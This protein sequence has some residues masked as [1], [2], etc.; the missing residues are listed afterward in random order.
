MV[1]FVI[2][3]IFHFIFVQ[4]FW[5]VTALP[6]CFITF[7][8]DNLSESNLK[9]FSHYLN[10]YCDHSFNSLLY[11]CRS[12][13][14]IRPPTRGSIKAVY[15]YLL[16]VMH[17]AKRAGVFDRYKRLMIWTTGIL[18]MHKIYLGLGN[19]LVLVTVMLKSHHKKIEFLL[20]VLCADREK[21]HHYDV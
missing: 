21:C 1:I 7:T 17:W 4:Y 14:F 3:T 15:R 8:V 12:I 20:I 19:S 13:Y 2:R 10:D 5:S 16:C 18:N 9:L 6:H 11:N